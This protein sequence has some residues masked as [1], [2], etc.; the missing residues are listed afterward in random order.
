MSKE[1]HEKAIQELKRLE[2]MPRCRGIHGQPQL[3][4]LA[5]GGAVEEKI[6]GNPRHQ[7]RGKDSE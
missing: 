6:E 4:G 3:P 2:L 1:V 5:A 7:G